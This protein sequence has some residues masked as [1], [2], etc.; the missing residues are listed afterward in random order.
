MHSFSAGQAFDIDLD[1]DSEGA[2]QPSTKN[3][4]KS[5]QSQ[6]RAL[7]H[8]S[9]HSNDIKAPP[10]IRR[11]SATQPISHDDSDEMSQ[12][13]SDL[14]TRN[15]AVQSDED[16]SEEDDDDAMNNSV[17]L[18]ICCNQLLDFL[19]CSPHA[20]V[21]RTSTP[22]PRRFVLVLPAACPHIMA[23]SILRHFLRLG[24]KLMSMKS[25]LQS[26]FVHFYSYSY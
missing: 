26:R 9:D 5:S 15:H 22:V 17:R 8:E 1:S 11:R 25:Q 19:I 2:Q 12:V 7:S 3:Q 16:I 13:G 20:G 23:T 4:A 21:M 18:L 6:A 10:V 14:G 24:T